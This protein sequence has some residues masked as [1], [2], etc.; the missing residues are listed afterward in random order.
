MA[1]DLAADWLAKMKVTMAVDL[2]RFM[3]AGLPPRAIIERLFEIPE[4]SQA[5]HLRAHRGRP[6]ALDPSSPEQKREIVEALERM[7]G[8]LDDGFHEALVE[9]LRGIAAEVSLQE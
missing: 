4:V 7:A 9:E 5:F 2:S 3:S 6:L 1:T 8:W